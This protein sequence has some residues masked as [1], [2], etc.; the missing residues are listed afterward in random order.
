M[1]NGYTEESE[2]VFSENREY[3]HSVKSLYENVIV[4]SRILFYK[5]K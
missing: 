3:L 4:W 5:S 2:L 1:S